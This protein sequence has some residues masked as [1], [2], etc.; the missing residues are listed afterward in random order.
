MIL[1]L[2]SWITGSASVFTINLLAD[3]AQ[4]VSVSLSEVSAVAS[5]AII[6]Y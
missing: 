3:P 2:D 4:S 5:L 6:F 1:Y